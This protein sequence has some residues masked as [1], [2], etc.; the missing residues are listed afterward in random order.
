MCFCLNRSN[1]AE[2]LFREEVPEHCSNCLNGGRCIQGD[3]DEPK[4]FLCLCSSCYSGDRCQ[5]YLNSF[6]FSLDQ[7][8]YSNLI[9]T[10]KL[11]MVVALIS[12]SMLHFVLSLPNNIFVLATVKRPAF[13]RSSVAQ[14]LLGMSISNQF[15]LAFFVARLTHLSLKISAINSPT[16]IDAFLCKSLH[17]L[18]TSSSRLVYWLSTWIAIERLY[19]TVVVQG[20]RLNNPHTARHIIAI[21]MVLILTSGVYEILFIEFLPSLSSR[22]ASMCIGRFPAHSQTMWSLVHWSV[23][24]FH[25]GLP[26]VINLICTISISIVVVMKKMKTTATHHGK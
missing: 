23:S 18:L 21:L 26:L 15:N 19:M 2:C 24:L 4:D 6:S 1:P 8:F 16:M 14:Y 22:M 3:L 25:T 12:A 13:R 17:Y 7:L 20:K 9:S 5:F 10:H 11:R